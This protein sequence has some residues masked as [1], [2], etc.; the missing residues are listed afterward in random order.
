MDDSFLDGPDASNLLDL[1]VITPRALTSGT[2][3]P[4]GDSHFAD[5]ECGLWVVL[6][7]PDPDGNVLAQYSIL[8][9]LDHRIN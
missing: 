8:N 4:A 9:Y 6:E 2:M 7:G 3:I 1:I 5:Q